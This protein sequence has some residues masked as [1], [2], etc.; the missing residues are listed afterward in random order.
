MGVSSSIAIDVAHVSKAFRV[1]NEQYKT[2]KDKILYAGRAKYREFVAL[3]DVSLSVTKGS[4]VGLIGVNGSGKS[5]LL[6]LISRILYPDQGAIQVHGRVSSLLELGAGFHPDFSGYENIFLNGALM[7][8]SKKELQKKVD[9]IVTFSELGDFIHEPIRSYSSGMYMRLAFSVAV[10]VEP[11]ILLIDEILAVGDAAFQAKCMDHLHQLQKQNK[12]IVI[13]THDAGVVERFCDEA[14]WLENAKVRMDG[15]PSVCIPAYLDAL[16]GDHDRQGT[17]RFDRQDEELAQVVADD[18][19]EGE[20]TPAHRDAITVR[21]T[22]EGAME[23]IRLWLGDP[24]TVHIALLWQPE[25]S[26]A[27]A[28]RLSLLTVTLTTLDQT[29]EVVFTYHLSQEEVSRQAEEEAD[30]V[31]DVSL[32]VPSLLIPVGAYLLSASVVT[33]DGEMLGKGNLSS[34]MYV[35]QVMDEQGQWLVPHTWQQR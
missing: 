5:T 31:I 2:L 10:A 26:I 30:E 25:Q 14:V 21:M 11:E 13:V 12:T 24:M 6:K 17:M 18:R 3:E 23:P 20:A 33:K 16:F 35:S 29:Q 9:S 4:T 1:H 19:Q 34:P 7:G 15:A 27:I 8:F 32:T 28:D 22:L